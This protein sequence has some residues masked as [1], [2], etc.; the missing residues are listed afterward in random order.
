MTN[1]T[2]WNYMFS[3]IT[4]AI[5]RR[6]NNFILRLKNPSLRLLGKGLLYNV[7]VEGRGRNTIH[8][9]AGSSL[10][11]CKIVFYKGINNLLHIPPCCHLRDITFYFENDNNLI[12]LGSFC[13]MEEGCQL[14]AVEGKRI[15]LGEDCMLS[16]QISIRTT[17]HH[18]ILDS[19]GNR[20]NPG[21]DVIIG[22]HVWI[23]Y[24]CL[25]LKGAVIPD[26]CVIG[27]RSLVTASLNANHNSLV[28]G[29]PAKIL[30]DNINWCRKR[31]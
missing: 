5:K 23:G 11:N 18:S 31:I 8:I 2:Y 24:Q 13:T 27:A 12:E 16:N 14:K 25:I 28:A 30:K 10:T 22:S 29:S 17:D 26:N 1:N 19:H 21:A 6:Y 3:K 7:K 20:L 4:T 9:E 15:I